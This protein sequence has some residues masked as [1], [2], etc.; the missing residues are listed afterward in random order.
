MRVSDLKQGENLAARTIL[1]ILSLAILKLAAFFITGMAVILADA[2]STF[3]DTLGLIAAYFGLKLSRKSEDKRFEYGYYKVETFMAFLISLGIIYLGWVILTNAVD[4]LVSSEEGTFRSFAITTTIISMALSY[5]LSK[6]LITMGK[7][8]NSLSLTAS[9]N[10]K[11]MDVLAG[12]AILG[13]IIANYQQLPYVEGI[14]TMIIAILILKEGLYSSKESLFYLLDYWDDPVLKKKIQKVLREDKNLVQKVKKIRMRRAGAF[15]FGEALIQV[16]PYAELSEIRDELNLLQS[17]IK[18]LSPYLR[19]FSI[20]THIQKHQELRVAI[21]IKKGKDLDAE[22]AR[23]LKETHAYIFADLKDNKVKK[24]HI[25]KVNKLEKKTMKLA[26]LFKKEKIQILIDNDLNSL[27]YY[28]LRKAN[29]ILV[30]PN[31]RDIRSASATLKLL[32]LD[33]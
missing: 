10:D 23:T 3:A 6:K 30:Y 2:I 7:K 28:N 21:P 19:D 24:F 33:I 4:T 11:R 16:N 13:S 20:L 8:V 1:L 9:G 18:E 12:F 31:F 25:I 26:E 27:L 32:T 15:I 14:I 5:R 22:V 17:K 29:H